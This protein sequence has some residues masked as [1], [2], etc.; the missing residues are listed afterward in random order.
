MLRRH[1]LAAALLVGCGGSQVVEEKPIVRD[2]ATQAPTDPDAERD[3]ALQFSEPLKLTGVVFHPE[4]L[5]EQQPTWKIDAR[6]TVADQRKRLEKAK[7]P[8][9]DAEADTLAGVLWM[10]EGKEATKE[11]RTEARAILRELYKDHGKLTEAQLVKLAQVEASLG[12]DAAAT[13]AYEEL[14]TRFEKSP[15]ASRYKAMRAFYQLRAGERGKAE[16]ILAGAGEGPEA[17]YLR[18]WLAFQGGD[19]AAAYKLA[20]AAEAKWPGQLGLAFLR[21]DL[22]LFGGRA[23]IDPDQVVPVLKASAKKDGANA[24]ALVAALIQSYNFGGHYALAQKLLT[25][26]LEGAP[27]E[28]AAQVRNTQSDLAY[29]LGQPDVATEHA[30]AAWEL[31]QKADKLE[32]PAK[33]ALLVRLYGLGAV[34]HRIYGTAF[35]RRYGDAAQKLYA[36]FLAAP[37]APKDK[38]EDAK[39]RQESLEQLLAKPQPKTGEHDKDEVGRFFLAHA[40][41]LVACYEQG[42]QGA[43]DLSG[44]VKLTLTVVETGQ[45]K[46]VTTEPPAGGTGLGA[47]SGCVAERVKAW[48]FFTRSRP[49]TTVIVFPMAFAPKK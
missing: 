17:G 46:S 7:G 39:L 33:E 3:Q 49:G 44:T 26:Y 8:A 27:P 12:D 28:V 45:V 36:A 14:G 48:S 43:P 24:D 38:L 22:I 19:A 37:S 2:P 35:D 5:S 13:T 11:Q 10:G 23:A 32:A 42:L 15:G 29:K 6:R 4:A 47:V 21:R 30:L 1:L 40:Q 41:E 31:A 18:A 34:Y 16:E 9:R 25:Q 20:V